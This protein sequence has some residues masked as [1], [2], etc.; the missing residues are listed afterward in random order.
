MPIFVEKGPDGMEAVPVDLLSEIVPN[1]DVNGHSESKTRQNDK[2]RRH[3]DAVSDGKSK[4][5][6]VANE[7]DDHDEPPDDAV[8]LLPL[9]RD[10]PLELLDRVICPF[11][12]FHG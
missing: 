2:R 3:V 5:D 9:E 8:E 7:N 1:E 11:L 10:A 6:A 12:V 4:V